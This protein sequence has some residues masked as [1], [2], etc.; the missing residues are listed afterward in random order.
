MTTLLIL[1]ATAIGLLTL[2]A[3]WFRPIVQ[4]VAADLA[5]TPAQRRPVPP[6]L[7]DPDCGIGATLM[8]AAASGPGASGS[9]GGSAPAAPKKPKRK[10]PTGPDRRAFLRN[11]W[12]LSMG[13]VLGAFGAA[14]L[15]FLW[16]RLGA[17]AFG[18]NIDL[19]PEEDVLSSIAEGGG[20]F[21]F[22]SGRLY[23]VQY[24]AANDPDGQYEDITNGASVMAIYQQCVHL[25]CRVPWCESSR[26][27]ECPCHGS[28]YNRWGEYEF[29]PAPRGLDR[30]P[31]TLTDGNVF[32]DTSTIVTGPTQTGGVL[33]E[34]AAGPN[35]NG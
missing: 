31:V 2:A 12:L 34:P 5:V 8:A 21:E 7:A 9:G 19:G 22:P 29:G 28:R 27:F 33:G 17:G 25:G 1:T 10:K 11:S 32:V 35:C 20:R 16:P 23:M 3:W 6:G 14:S 13:G 15:G 18:A 30:F 24:N 26:W 4:A